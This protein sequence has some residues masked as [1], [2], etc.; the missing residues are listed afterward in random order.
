MTVPTDQ[1]AIDQQQHRAEKYMTP[2][3]EVR[4]SP[5]WVMAELG[6]KNT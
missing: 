1:K 5:V 3:E 6:Y 2:K 4:I